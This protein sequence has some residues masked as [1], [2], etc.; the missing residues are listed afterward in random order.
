[1][2]DRLVQ[3]AVIGSAGSGQPVIL[4]E[5]P[6]NLDEYRRE[7]GRD[8]FWCGTLLG[9]CGQKLITKRYETKVCHFAHHPGHGESCHRSANGVDSADHLFLRKHVKGWLL[10]QGHAAKADLRSLGRGPG[11]AVDFWLRATAQHLRFELNPQDYVRWR[12]AAESL[13]AREGH[14]EW[15]FGGPDSAIT[16]DVVA[17]QGYALRLC[18]HTVGSDRQVNIGTVIDDGT[19][20]VWVPLDECRMTSDG[21]VTPRLEELRKQGTVRG[22]GMRND[23]FPASLPLRGAEIVFALDASARPPTA[24]PLVAADR[25]LV[26]G[27]IKPAGSRITRAH[28]SLPTGVPQPTED[29]VYRLDTMVRL[30][31]TEPAGAADGVVWAIR[32]DS[33]SQLKGLDAERTGLWRPSASLEEPRPDP[34]TDAS[35]PAVTPSTQVERSQTAATLRKELEKVAVRGGTTTWR[36]LSQLSGV[37]LA[38]LPDPKRRRLLL[39]VDSPFREDA[40]LLSVLVLTQ[41][42]RP[43]PYLATILRMLGAPAPASDTALQK[44]SREAIARTHTAYAGYDAP[45]AA[46][47]Q[48][49]AE[50]HAQ[51]VCRVKEAQEIIPRESGRRAARLNDAVRGAEELLERYRRSCR[52]RPD[53]RHWLAG[54]DSLLDTLDRL[55]GRPVSTALAPNPGQRTAEPDGVAADCPSPPTGVKNQDSRADP[56]GAGRGGVAQEVERLS[57]L[58]ERVKATG[59]LDSASKLLEQANGL[60]CRDGKAETKRQLNQL[61]RNLT[62][63]IIQRKHEDAGDTLTSLR[64]VLEKA[65]NVSSDAGPVR[66]REILA[67]ILSQAKAYVHRLQ[68]PLPDNVQSEMEALQQR[69]TSSLPAASPLSGDPEPEKVSAAPEGIGPATATRSARQELDLLAEQARKAQEAG[70][71]AAV[72]AARRRMGPLYALRLTDQERQ[73][74]T[75]LLRQLKQWCRTRDPQRQTDPALRK[76]RSLLNQ[77]GSRRFSVTVQ[78]IHGTL[79]DIRR[80]RSQLKVPLPD[81]DRASIH[82]W[83]RR[84]RHVKKSKSRASQLT[85]PVQ[86]PPNRT[87]QN[88]DRLPQERISELADAVR[89]ILEDAARTGGLLT[90]GGIRKRMDGRL[91][92]LHPD[93]QGELLVVVDQGT[94]AEEPLLSALVASSDASL[95]WLYRHVR[96]SL[97]RKHIT[98]EDLAA[99]WPMEVLRLRQRWRHR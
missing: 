65:S 26:S 46:D 89:S 42:G 58:F 32:C 81:S 52:W 34:S 57:C 56:P 98:D 8:Q 14:I 35:A 33:L 38:H 88:G 83:Q 90:W 39:E 45:N 94:P 80:L 51:L 41:A 3:T 40:P 62:E 37:D 67:S 77:L 2:D 48:A 64:S 95:H 68:Q 76:I 72:E 20:V 28:V 75:P 70:D 22:G 87:Q 60:H 47:L 31:I 44:W 17:R 9:G 5:A 84:L 85:D 92:H 7:F 1:M 21:I 53:T 63:W 66:H 74:F 30:L 25:Y 79:G 29:Y 24:G 59:N 73:G 12:T 6:H 16:R 71:L 69:L 23:P 4:P 93:D 19:D 78:E 86:F 61:R 55:I 97:G 49:A 91:P 36:A 15:V 43:L 82:R 99:H 50:R 13:G 18:L 54:S 96:F 11:D 10:R 27:F